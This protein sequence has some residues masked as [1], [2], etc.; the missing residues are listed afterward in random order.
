MWYTFVSNNVPTFFL[1]FNECLLPFFFFSSNSMRY[2]NSAIIHPSWLYMLSFI[3]PI[4]NSF[5]LL[6]V[7]HLSRVRHTDTSLLSTSSKAIPSHSRRRLKKTSS[8]LILSSS[9]PLTLSR[10]RPLHFDEDGYDIPF[11]SS[12]ITVN[13]A[14][15][16]FERDRDR[17]GSFLSSPTCPSVGYPPMMSIDEK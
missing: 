2:T 15:Y 12:R 16:P 1:N 17:S 4:K 10:Y 3:P 11:D 7:R 13:S 14:D 9:L 5:P 6:G 8:N